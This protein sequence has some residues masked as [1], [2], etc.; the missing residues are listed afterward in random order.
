MSLTI[1]FVC[2]A[3]GLSQRTQASYN[4]NY[5]MTLCSS[6]NAAHIVSLTT[7]LVTETTLRK[8]DLS[9]LSETTPSSVS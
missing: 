6:C 3:C 7:G 2:G 1:S 8:E 9:G 4:E 5:Y